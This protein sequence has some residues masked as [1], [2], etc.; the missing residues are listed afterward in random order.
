MKA[1]GEGL[2]RYC[3]GVYRHEEFTE[4]APTADEVAGRRPISPTAFV[5]VDGRVDEPIPWVSGE[6]LAT[7]DAVA[8]PAEFVHYPPPAERHRPAITTGLGLGNSGVEALL[9]G[10]YEVIERDATMLAWYS[11]IEPV[12]LAVDAPGYE[13]LRRRARAENLSVTPLLVTADVDVPALGRGAGASRTPA[14]IGRAS[15]RER[16]SS[17]V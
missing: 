9:S 4:A 12:G 5:G 6:A 13:T 17:P 7:G 8:L 1:L 11:T 15:C 14:Q 2:E 16:V 3:A 10:L